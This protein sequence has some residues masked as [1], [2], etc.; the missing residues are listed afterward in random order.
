MEEGMQVAEFLAIVI[1]PCCKCIITKSEK[2]VALKL[3]SP[4]SKDKANK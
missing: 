1:C 2:Y 3:G 4:V